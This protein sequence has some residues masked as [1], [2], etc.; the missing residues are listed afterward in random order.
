[1]QK[2]I[3]LSLPQ[4]GIPKS[5]QNI[6]QFPSPHTRF[7]QKKPGGKTQTKHPC[8]QTTRLQHIYIAWFMAFHPFVSRHNRLKITLLFLKRLPLS[9]CLGW[10]VPRSALR[11]AA[12]A[13]L[14]VL[15][16]LF[17]FFRRTCRFL[18]SSSSYHSFHPN[19]SISWNKCC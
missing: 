9:L 1:M 17:L 7:T 6:E 13:L 10:R 19:N 14:K 16:G 12:S 11:V 18:P 8:H 3:R 2:N 15:L 5:R 4:H